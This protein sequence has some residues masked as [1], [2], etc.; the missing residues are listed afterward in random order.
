MIVSQVAESDTAWAAPGANA[1]GIQIEQTAHAGWS[2]EWLGGGQVPLDMLRNTAEVMAGISQRWGIP[3]VHLS[4]DELANGASGVIG[5]VQAS[6]VY[7]QSD[8]WDPGPSY[9]YDYVID[10]ARQFA[11]GFSPASVPA[12]PL[13]EWS[14]LM[15]DQTNVQKLDQIRDIV[16]GALGT[17][18]P[19]LG[20]GHPPNLAEVWDQANLGSTAAIKSAGVVDA[21]GKAVNVISQQVVGL[22]TKVDT[23]K[24]GSGKTLAEYSDDEILAEAFRRQNRP[25]A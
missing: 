13:D 7:Q 1:D 23:V 19:G 4:N 21:V 5:H 6:E 16:V 15:A 2:T 25:K 24:A 9:P 11:G 12:E 14:A 17:Y 3:L 22:T 10:L 18:K 8:H 20:L